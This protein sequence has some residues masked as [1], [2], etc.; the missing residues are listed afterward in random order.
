MTPAQAGRL[1]DEHDTRLWRVLQ[2][3]VEKARAE[4][5]FSEVTA[6]RGR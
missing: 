2:H 6:C 3:Y 5:D 1:I 4:A